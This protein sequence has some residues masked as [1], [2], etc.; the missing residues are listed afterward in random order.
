[1][2]WRSRVILKIA[3]V[4]LSTLY[5]LKLTPSHIIHCII[6][7]VVPDLI[8]QMAHMLHSLMTWQSQNILQ[9]NIIPNPS[10]LSKDTG[11][12]TPTDHYTTKHY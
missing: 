5:V 1:M 4:G 12:P 10:H 8:P 3:T 7:A 9:T 2:L 11:T 6:I